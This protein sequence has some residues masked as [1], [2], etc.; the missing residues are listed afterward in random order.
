MRT[1][2]SGVVLDSDLPHLIGVDDDLLS[3]G[4]VMYHIKVCVDT[5]QLCPTSKMEVMSLPVDCLLKQSSYKMCVQYV[6]LLQ[7][8]HSFGTTSL[9]YAGSDITSAGNDITPILNVGQ[10]LSTVAFFLKLYVCFVSMVLLVY[11]SLSHL[12]TLH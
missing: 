9:K 6:E 4:L 11:C 3:T 2:G 10:S 8:I 1:E 5:D 7:N 12:V